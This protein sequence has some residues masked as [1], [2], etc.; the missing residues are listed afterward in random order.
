MRDTLAAVPAYG[1]VFR[2]KAGVG[3][4]RRVGHEVTFAASDEFSGRLPVDYDR[5]CPLHDA[6][7]QGGARGDRDPRTRWRATAMFGIAAP[8]HTVIGLAGA[9]T[10]YGRP[11]P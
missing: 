2:S 5:E 7:E 4:P 10:A 1:H 8:R 6:A 9:P 11:D 3:K